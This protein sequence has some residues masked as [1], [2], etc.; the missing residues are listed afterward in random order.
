MTECGTNSCQETASIRMFW[1]GKE[2]MPVCVPCADRA[3]NIAEAMGFYL[4][5]ELIPLDPME[6]AK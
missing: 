5:M 2:P 4:H 1:P 6:T 3:K